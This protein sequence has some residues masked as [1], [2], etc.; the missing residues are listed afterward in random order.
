MRNGFYTTLEQAR[1]ELENRNHLRQEVEDWWKI[2][3]GSLPPLPKVENM[4]ILSRHVATARYED[5]VFH[6]L[7]LQA[8]LKP[9][10]LEYL[11]DTYVD[12]SNCKR[13]Y[14]KRYLCSG[15]GRNNGFILKKQ[16]LTN[17][18][19]WNGRPLYSI[20]T[21]TGEPLPE[22][23]HGEQDMFFNNPVRFD[24][25]PWLQVFGKAK[26]YYTYY[27]SLF[28][29]HAVLFEDYH[30]GESGDVLDDFTSQIFEPSFHQLKTIFGFKPLIVPMP[31]FTAMKYYPADPDWRSHKV[32]PQEYC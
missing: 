3:E 6:Q 29:A 5:I 13:S 11:S 31:W 22:F 18:N 20:K 19:R 14:V 10:W 12:V 9:V 16:V 24:L 26:D 15:I 4:A 25:S 8:G 32:V 7:A 27:L 17:P 28:L 23:H 1:A 30:G 2:K 21:N